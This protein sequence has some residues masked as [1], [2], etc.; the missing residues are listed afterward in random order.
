MSNE[1]VSYRFT[2]VS[3][4]EKTF[5][6]H[7]RAHLWDFRH[8]ATFFYFF[9]PIWAFFDVLNT[10]KTFFGYFS[11]LWKLWKFPKS[12]PGHFWDF[13][14]WYL[15]GV[16]TL[17]G[18]VLS[19]TLR[20]AYYGTINYTHESGTFLL[21][22]CMVYHTNSPLNTCHIHICHRHRAWCF[23]CKLNVYTLQWTRAGSRF[24]S[25]IEGILSCEVS[26]E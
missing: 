3:T 20:G 21:K 6:M 12:G 17:D 13:A 25:V 19:Q 9:P 10:I 23:V 4:S 2:R 11:P 16:P 24:G 18:S 8:C 1:R 7:K 15:S 5:S 14:F 22:T 26:W